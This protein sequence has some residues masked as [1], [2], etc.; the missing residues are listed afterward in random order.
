MLLKSDD[1]VFMKKTVLF[2]QHKCKIIQGNKTLQWKNKLFQDYELNNNYYPQ[3][4]RRVNEAGRPVRHL[5]FLSS[6]RLFLKISTE[7]KRE[8]IVQ[9]LM[10]QKIVIIQEMSLMNVD[11]FRYL[12]LTVIFWFSNCAKF[13]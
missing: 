2:C 3:S 1:E 9:S 8:D 12:V 5:I 13:S 7:M 11:Y 4:G 6:R 10:T